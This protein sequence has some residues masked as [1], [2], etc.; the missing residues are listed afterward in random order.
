MK[1]DYVLNIPYHG[2]DDISP[3]L[4]VCQGFLS[5]NCVNILMKINPHFPNEDENSPIE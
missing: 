1:I 5:V 3:V 4:N 2:T